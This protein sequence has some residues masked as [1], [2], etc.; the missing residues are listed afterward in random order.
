MSNTEYQN[1]SEHD[2]QVLIKRAITPQVAADR[3]YRTWTTQEARDHGFRGVNARDGLGIP[4][5][6]TQG[7]TTGHQLRPHAPTTDENGRNKKYLWP[8]DYPTPITGPPAA[9]DKALAEAHRLREDVT[10]PVVI[11][12]SI[13]KLDGDLGGARNLLR[14]Q[15]QR[16]L[17]LARQR[18]A[19]SELPRH[20]APDQ[21]ARQGHL[22]APSDHRSRQ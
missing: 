11:F 17:R 8:V 2:S 4:A 10:V 13:L 22:S 1:L 9:T 14:H 5:P 12:E 21:E 3:G 6:N 20:P 18:R 15:H 16:G 7:E 19:R